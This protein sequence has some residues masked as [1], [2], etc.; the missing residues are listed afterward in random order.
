[1]ATN[2]KRCLY[3][4]LGGTG[5][6]SILHTKKMFIDTYGE[7]P[8][9]IGFIG[10]DTDR[11]EYKGTLKLK[12]GE[13][14]SLS[15]SEQLK[16]LVEEPQDIYW[17]NKERFSWVP[18]RNLP[19]LTYM[20]NG[21]GQLRSNGRFAFTVNYVNIRKK[22]EDVL[23][24]ITN[25]RI[26]DNDKYQ[27]LNTAT[28][29]HMVFSLSGGT[30]S[31]TFINMAYLIK[32]LAP[33]CKITG[34]AVLPGVFRAMARSGMANVSANTYGAIKDLDYLMHMGLG[35]EPFKLEYLRDSENYDIKI[36]PFNS[37]IFIDNKNENLD[38]Y[39]N[40]SELAEMI[41]LALVT[42]SGEL[43]TA[44]AS[45]SDNI[46]KYID[47]GEMDIENK[48]AWASGMGICEIVY[49]GN[50][51]SKIYGIKAAKNIIERLLNSCVDTDLIVNSWIDS[52]EVNIREN[53]GSDN[54]IDYLWNKIP[55]YDLN[56]SDYGNPKP[57]VDINLNSNVVD[58]QKINAKVSALT[59]KVRTEL[60][61]LIIKHTNT[62]CGVST[63]K[64][65]LDGIRAQVDIFMGEMQS[66]KDEFLEKEPAYIAQV[67]TAI[68]DLRT[69]DGKFFKKKSTLDALADDL[70]EAVKTLAQCRIEIARRNAA[71]A[72]F[73]DVLAAVAE[74]KANIVLIEN[75]LKAVY[76]ELTKDLAALTNNVGRASQTFQI[77]LSKDVAG[78]ISVDSSKI[79]IEDFVKNLHHDGKVYSFSGL[80]HAEIK[81]DILGYAEKLRPAKEFRNTTIDDIIDGL[82]EDKFNRIIEIAISKSK[83][84]FRYSYKGYTPNTT[85]R[86]SF[87]IGVPDKVVSR[88]YKDDYFKQR[89]EG[90]M[91]VDFSNTGVTDKIIFYRQLGVVP[92]Y[93]LAS[94]RDYEDEHLQC[95]FNNF[96]DQNL[97]R[98]FLR[99]DFS[100]NPKRASE[101]DLLE[102]WVKGFIFDLIRNTDDG[103]E[104][105]SKELGKALRDY[106]MPLSKYRDE[107]FDQFKRYKNTVRNEYQ[108]IIDKKAKEM[109]DEAM[110]KLIERVKETYFK[111]FSQL[112]MTVNEL[113]KKGFEK[114]GELMEAELQYVDKE[115]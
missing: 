72:V 20:T 51:L 5:M 88:L 53:N 109:G 66:E 54:V 70:A 9:M 75:S 58:S 41:S 11:D 93:T 56:V 23:N 64:N 29:I 3:I 38:A 40:I 18:D 107:A 98:R 74:A 21:A 2:V 33:K 112:N 106:W 96:F 84:L 114:V 50:T 46:E 16:I 91:D 32:E 49:D 79:Q 14:M 104:F 110:R 34:Y 85:P 42:A 111:D 97:E 35:K 15:P 4:G 83:P 63:A 26:I 31:G 10:I 80:S 71:I 61:K 7:V 90:S 92:P 60:R 82:S 108:D 62:E 94:I 87:Y 25:A 13:E 8:P 12:N 89:L 27:L 68:Q 47:A 6:K 69:A 77:D 36:R 65:I 45:V 28:E 105:K 30:G 115:L 95:R 78:S 1:M 100:I 19:G 17:V 103:Y 99:E 39:T 76:E 67:E 73:N 48:K 86:D 24:S 57:E 43:S 52:A 81:S 22:V 101:D 102:F 55:K 59:S 37:F 113:E 44:S